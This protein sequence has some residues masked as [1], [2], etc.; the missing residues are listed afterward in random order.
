MFIFKWL[1]KL[2][3][4]YWLLFIAL[5]VFDVCP[6]NTMIGKLIKQCQIKL[7]KNIHVN[8][9]ASNTNIPN[10]Q[11]VTETDTQESLKALVNIIQ[12]LNQQQNIPAEANKSNNRNKQ[13]S[14]DLL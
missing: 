2:S 10:S 8:N 12:Q 13:D 9:N 4:C 14:S 1:L 3:F 11:S 7:S 6:G 5:V